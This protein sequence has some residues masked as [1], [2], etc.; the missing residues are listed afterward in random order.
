MSYKEEI[1]KFVID[2]YK[3]AP[4]SIS[5]F[6]TDG[7][8]NFVLKNRK[9]NFI[10]LPPKDFDYHRWAGSLKSSQAFAYNIF[11][12]VKN[13]ELE[14]EFKMNVFDRPAQVDV[15]LEDIQTQTIELFEVKMFEIIKK[16][17]V[18]FERKYDIKENYIY[19]SEDVADAFIK[20]KNEVIK[21]FD[22]KKIYGG[23]IKQLCSHL[24]GIL[25]IMNK[26]QYKNKKFKLHSLC[27]D[28]EFSDKFKQ[29]LDNYIDTLFVFK[30]LVDKFL[31]E[32]RVDS[33]VEYCGFLSATDYII[34]KATKKLLGKGN[35]DYV[36][37]RY[38][39]LL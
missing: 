1:E 38:L 20:F 18:E 22:G 2:G 34:F 3:Y 15:K 9:D 21:K 25:N 39:Y 27:L 6:E 14:F 28:I 24:L 12:G 13:R 35:Y 31:K 7:K 33:R 23:G 37:K 36:M 32:I 16:E 19:L 10:T 30:H 17:K 4:H 29:D 5:T 8:H 11:S 26:P